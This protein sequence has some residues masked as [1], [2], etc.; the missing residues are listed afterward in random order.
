MDKQGLVVP[1]EDYRATTFTNDQK[2]QQQG[3]K[4][5]NGSHRTTLDCRTSK[6][7]ERCPFTCSIFFLL[8]TT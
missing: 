8:D 2:N 1:R 4:G 7:D 6:G 5:I 3:I